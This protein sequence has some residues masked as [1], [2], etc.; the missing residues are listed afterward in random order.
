[1]F[2]LKEK[3]HNTKLF[4][5]YKLFC[6]INDYLENKIFDSLQNKNYNNYSLSH[7]IILLACIILG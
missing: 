7:N 6:Q 5:T 1:M 4:I 2:E 3:T